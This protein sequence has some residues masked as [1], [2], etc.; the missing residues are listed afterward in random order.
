MAKREQWELNRKK[1]Q[2]VCK[3]DHKEMEM[4]LNAVYRKGL[5]AGEKVAGSFDVNICLEAIS[6]IKGIGPAKIEQIRLAMI[7]AGAKIP[8]E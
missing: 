3:M 5:V 4:Y 6:E 1:Y 8:E 7:A 2:E